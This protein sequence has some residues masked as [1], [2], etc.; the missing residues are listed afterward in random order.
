MNKI[1]NYYCYNGAF[2]KTENNVID[3]NNRAFN[4]GDAFFE[5]I[6]VSKKKVIN[7][8]RHIDRILY[9]SKILQFDIPYYFNAEFIENKI[10]DLLNRNKLFG[11]TRIKILIFRNSSGFYQ[12]N[13]NEINYLILSEKL[14][15]DKYIYNSK[16]LL[17]DY[18]DDI[19]KP[20]NVL[21]N[22]KT[23]NSLLYILAGIYKKNNNFD[24]L[25]ILN[26]DEFVC[27]TISSNIFLIKEN[28]LY[29]PSL[30][31]GCVK[32]IMRE[33]I[34][35]VALKIKMTVIDESHITL[36]EIELADE[37]FLTNSI[38]GIK[39]VMGYKQIRYYNNISKKIFNELI[40]NNFD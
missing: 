10:I 37:V 5:T 31:D 30:Q 18:Y 35:D 3:V 11:G 38:N 24:E 22:L 9:S 28:V 12:P 16:G 34:I 15:Y 19:K 23:T 6:F 7:I 29:T 2:Y 33:N 36:K 26:Q 39:W 40:R 4:Y 1:S 17:I 25:I 32:G 27:E 13:K 8:E 14:N 20:I 21:S